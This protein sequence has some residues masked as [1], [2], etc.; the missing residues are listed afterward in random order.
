MSTPPAEAGLT[1]KRVLVVGASG[2]GTGA[3][4]NAEEI[5]AGYVRA[6]LRDVDEKSSRLGAPS[7]PCR[8]AVPV[9]IGELVNYRIPLVPNAWRIAKGHRLRLVLA[10]ADEDSDAPT[11]LGFRHATVGTSTV[12]IVHSSSRLILPFAKQ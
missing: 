1:G 5:T 3:D 7:L 12:N 2:R 9:P 11:F 6:S 10:S 8:T 4:G